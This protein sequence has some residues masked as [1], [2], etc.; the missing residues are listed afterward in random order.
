[1]WY[2]GSAGR[3]GVPLSGAGGGS[4]ITQGREELYHY[5]TNSQDLNTS[6]NNTTEITQ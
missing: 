2:G 6:N 4:T 5:Y 3:G 1:M